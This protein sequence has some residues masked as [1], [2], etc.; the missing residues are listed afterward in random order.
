MLL[1]FACVSRLLFSINYRQYFAPG[2]Y[3]TP[4]GILR[5][6]RAWAQKNGYADIAAACEHNIG[7]VYYS[8]DRFGPAFEHLLK[9]DEERRK[10]GYENVPDIAVYLYELSIRLL[11]I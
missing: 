6:T 8:V 1:T 9:A 4:A 7:Q 2:D 3:E 5:K 10:I 11:Q